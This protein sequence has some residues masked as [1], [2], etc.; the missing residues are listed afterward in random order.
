MIN[1]EHYI[2]KCKEHE[3]QR[4]SFNERMQYWKL[5]TETNGEIYTHEDLSSDNVS[6][7]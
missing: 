6:D 5:Y 1:I 3:E 7:D 4:L 2:Q